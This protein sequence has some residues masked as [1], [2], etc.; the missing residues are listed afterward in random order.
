MNNLSKHDMN[1][2]MPTRLLL[3][4]REILIWPHH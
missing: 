2:T 3:Y 4:F 1:S